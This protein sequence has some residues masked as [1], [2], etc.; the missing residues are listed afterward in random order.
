M[1][2]LIR[3]MSESAVEHIHE[4]LEVMKQDIAVIKHILSEEGKLSEH[5]QKLLAEVRKTPESEYISHEELKK[6]VLK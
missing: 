2:A 4:D 6:R 3:N 1:N 5:A